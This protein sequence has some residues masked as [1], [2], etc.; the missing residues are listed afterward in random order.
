MGFNGLRSIYEVTSKNNIDKGAHFA[1]L[2]WRSPERI[3]KREE[4]IREEKRE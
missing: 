1:H 3:Q 4:I 2:Q